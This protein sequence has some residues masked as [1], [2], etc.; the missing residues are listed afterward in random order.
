[1][2]KRPGCYDLLQYR[3]QRTKRVDGNIEDAFDGEIYHE[4]LQNGFLANAHNMGFMWYTD[5]I[6]LY[7]S[8][9]F[10]MWPIFLVSNE[11]SY[12]ERIRKENIIFAGIWFGATEPNPNVSLEPL[13]N[14]FDLLKKEGHIFER[15]DGPPILVHAKILLGTRDLQA[16]C[17]CMCFRQWNCYFGCLKCLIRGQ[18]FFMN[19]RSSIHVYPYSVN[20]D[21]RQ[22]CPTSSLPRATFALDNVVAGRTHILSANRGWGKVH[23]LL[24]YLKFN[25]S[26]ERFDVYSL[27]SRREPQRV[28]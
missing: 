22:C 26:N 10:S 5:G 24:F 11:L 12:K 23:F 3:F 15:A 28:Q 8:S 18:R 7:K 25:E 27:T 6:S 9:N 16:K 17:R 1:M 13:N 14:N 21:L 4:Q 19:E 2:L 20:I